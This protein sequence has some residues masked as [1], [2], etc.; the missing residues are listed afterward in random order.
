MEIPF[1]CA[2]FC[3]AYGEVVLQFQN[4]T[5]VNGS[6]DGELRGQSCEI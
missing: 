6:V 1:P 5:F 2:H 4:S 3:P